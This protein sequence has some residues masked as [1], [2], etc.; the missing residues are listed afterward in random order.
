VEPNADQPPLIAIVGQTASGK[1]GLALELA[2]LVNGEVIAADSRT[3]YRGMN[4][5]TAKPTAQELAMTPHH[6][7][8]IVAPDQSFNV[9]MFQQQANQAIGAIS[10][11]GHVPLV[12][13]G[14]GLY[15]DALLFGFQFA[16]QAADPA[17][18]SQMELYSVPELQEMIL[19]NGLEL[20]RNVQNPRHLIRTLERDGEVPTRH[21]LR[22]N[23]LVLG[24]QIDREHL[25]DKI[26]R[27][28]QLMIEQGLVDE[29]RRLSD[30]YGWD[31][32]AMQAP[33]YKAFRG[34]IEGV[35]TLEESA[36]LFVQLD[37]QY[38]KR[39]KTWFKR[40]KSIHWISKTEE[41]VDIVTTF[42][43][44]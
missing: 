5:G 11:R 43:N 14:T 25:L 19:S 12:V 32:P 38:A 18:R 29:A 22:P 9:F 8:D 36:K 7:I 20:P 10:G 40:N 44:K 24:L 27:R 16:G 39:Q 3:V 31:V 17:R 35:C 15:V 2:H 37:M 1:T 4:I 30:Q 13:G 42:L 6:L 21:E 34:Y 41:A 23:T 26:T 33:A 28:V